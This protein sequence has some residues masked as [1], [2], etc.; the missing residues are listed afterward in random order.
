MNKELDSEAMIEV[1]KA[2]DQMKKDAENRREKQIAKLWAPIQLPL[3]LKEAL[4]KLTRDQL[5]QIRKHLDIKN[6]SSLKKCCG[7]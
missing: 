7:R 2:L 1:L 4:S 3:T 6:I 5:D